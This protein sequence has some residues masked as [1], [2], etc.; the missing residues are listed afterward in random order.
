ML[1]T[2]DI[3][4]FTL[5][6]IRINMKLANK[7]WIL[8]VIGTSNF[9]ILIKCVEIRCWPYYELILENSIW[10]FLAM[11]PSIIMVPLGFSP[12]PSKSERILPFYFLIIVLGFFLTL[13]NII[14]GFFTGVL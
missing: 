4:K 1:L 5:R 10:F 12:P 14:L 11:L 6:K 13:H 2:K 8:I 3:Q 9:F 7:L